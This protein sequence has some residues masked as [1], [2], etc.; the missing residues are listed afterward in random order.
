VLLLFPKHVDYSPKVFNFAKYVAAEIS[1]FKI[2]AFVIG[3]INET[4]Q[5]AYIIM[6]NI[7]VMW[8]MV[9]PHQSLGQ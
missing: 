1:I 7:S 2:E 8:Y 9:W 3:S 5:A 6:F 4:Q